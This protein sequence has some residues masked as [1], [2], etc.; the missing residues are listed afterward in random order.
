MGDCKI[1]WGKCVERQ[2]KAMRS[3][4][5][6]VQRSQSLSHTGSPNP[7]AFVLSLIESPAGPLAY[8]MVCAAVGYYNTVDAMPRL[9]EPPQTPHSAVKTS[10][11]LQLLGPHAV[12]FDR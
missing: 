12:L 8:T 4:V 1:T 3:Y 7:A 5:L 11:P 9:V 6:D 2:P 10:T